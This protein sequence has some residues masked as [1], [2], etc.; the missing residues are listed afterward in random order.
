[1][2]IKLYKFF[3]VVVVFFFGGRFCYITLFSVILLNHKKG[4]LISFCILAWPI[5]IYL[6]TYW[7]CWINQTLSR[8]YA[9]RLIFNLR[10]CFLVHNLLL[11]NLI[12]VR[13]IKWQEIL[14]ICLQIQ[15]KICYKKVCFD[16]LSFTTHLEAAFVHF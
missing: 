6:P 4:K 2:R 8:A 16:S 1:M 9:A 10:K 12:Y 15:T 7:Q 11:I 3:V 13:N 5:I 14:L